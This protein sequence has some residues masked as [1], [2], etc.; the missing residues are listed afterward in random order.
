MSRR[1]PF[2]WITGLLV[3]G[4]SF[5]SPAAGAASGDVKHP[6]LLITRAM[7]PEI[8]QKVKTE[9]WAAELW[10]K[11]IKVY[12]DRPHGATPGRYEIGIAYALTGDKVY[13][14][15]LHKLVLD[16]AKQPAENISWQWGVAVSSWATVNIAFTIESGK[17]LGIVFQNRCAAAAKDQRIWIDE[18]FIGQEP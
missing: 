10:G 7:I 8:R 4:L 18:V 1:P 9:P 5:L 6:C 13:G 2:F 17:K 14:E 12:A 15:K 3:S 16:I 11:V